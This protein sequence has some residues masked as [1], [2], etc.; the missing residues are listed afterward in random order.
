[1]QKVYFAGKF[2]IEK[3]FTK[4][5]SDR[6]ENDYRA[7]ILGGGEKL[8]IP[9]NKL[10][11]TKEIL[12]SGPFYCEQA[13]NGNF[14]ST[15]CNAIVD[16]EFK[17]VRECNLYF[18][19]F[20]EAFSVGTIVELG[21]AIENKKDIIIFYKEEE[22]SYAIKSDYWFAICD[23]IKRAKSIKVFSFKDINEVIETIKDGEIFN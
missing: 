9:S 12:Y 22:S 23:A 20:D 14:T 7:K 4:K 2:N 8:S 16:S 13:S 17:A 21:W 3:N 10:F 15:D 19:V 5:L 18:A 6:L 1:M 11:I